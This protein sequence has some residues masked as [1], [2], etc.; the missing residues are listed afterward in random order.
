MINN[1]VVRKAREYALGEEFTDFIL[2]DSK[3]QSIILNIDKMYFKAVYKEY[4]RLGYKLVHVT[5]FQDDGMTCVF[6]KSISNK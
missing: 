4:R 6:V 1:Y 3:R 5:R 2:I